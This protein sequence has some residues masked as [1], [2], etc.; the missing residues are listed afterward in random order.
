MCYGELGAL[1]E[2]HSFREN[3]GIART[4]EEEEDWYQHLSALSHVYNESK[5][6]RGLS[7]EQNG[8]DDRR[9]GAELEVGWKVACS[10]NSC[11]K[12]FTEACHGSTVLGGVVFLVNI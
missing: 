3:Y 6:Q 11:G 8:N 10:N 4:T 1:Q 7:T 5:G 9:C 12:L 2:R